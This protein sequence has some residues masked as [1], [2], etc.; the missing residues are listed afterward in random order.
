MFGIQ[1]MIAIIVCGILI[2][3]LLS[4]FIKYKI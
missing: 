3:M 2:A 4:Y 1:D